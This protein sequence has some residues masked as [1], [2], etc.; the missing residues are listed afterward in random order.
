MLWRL[1]GFFFRLIRSFPITIKEIA[2]KVRMSNPTVSRILN[3]KPGFQVKP[4]KRDLVL[5]LARELG[6]HPNMAARSLRSG[7]QYA[8]GVAG[9][10]SLADMSDVAA[11][12]IYAGIGKVV[13]QHGHHRTFFSYNNDFRETVLRMARQKMVDGMVLINYAPHYESFNRDIVPLLHQENMPFVVVH[14]HTAPY[15]CHNVGLNIEQAGALAARHLVEQGY[16]A[17]SLVG[18]DHSPFGAGFRQGCMTVLAGAGLSPAEYAYEH[19]N[20]SA[21]LGYELGQKV[22]AH[23]DA[24]DAYYLVPL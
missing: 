1:S 14:T 5:K 2:R 16:R 21:R 19:K 11:G 10:G 13:E 9:A 24:S 17:I 18:Y 8:I 4:E 15:A 12:M 20:I 22:L 6:Y 7:R 3:G 23:G